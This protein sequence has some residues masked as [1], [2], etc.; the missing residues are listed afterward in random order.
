[1]TCFAYDSETGRERNLVILEDK[2]I[3]NDNKMSRRELSIDMA[4]HRNIFQNEP[5]MLFSRFTFIPRS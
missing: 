2:P 5:I 1:M 3:N 4:I